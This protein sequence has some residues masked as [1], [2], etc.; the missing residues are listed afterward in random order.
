MFDWILTG[1]WVRLFEV[2][3]GISLVAELLIY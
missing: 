2:T 1:F 3:G